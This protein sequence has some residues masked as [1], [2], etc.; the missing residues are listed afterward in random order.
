VTGRVTIDAHRDARKPAAIIRVQDQRLY[1]AQP[2]ERMAVMAGGR[3][4]A[5]A[6]PPTPVEP[7]EIEIRAQMTVVVAIK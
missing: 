3:G 1:S 2:T 6:P 7:G 4:G 5:A